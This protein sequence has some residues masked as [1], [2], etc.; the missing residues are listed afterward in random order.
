[1]TLKERKLGRE[2]RRLHK[3]NEV[4]TEENTFY[5]ERYEVLTEENTFY[6]ERY[7]TLTAEN[8]HLWM[9][10]QTLKYGTADLKGKKSEKKV[11]IKPNT[12]GKKKKRGK[13][14]G[15][16]G[17]SR[18]IPDHVD[19]VVDIIL[20]F[21]P[22]CGNP[23][24]KPFEVTKRYIE[25]IIPSTPHVTQVNTGR[26]YCTCCKK[27]VSAQSHD[28]LP[29]C[30]LGLNVTF[31]AAYMKYELHLPLAKI[32]K[33]LE[34]CFGLKTTATTIYRHIKLLS[35][36]Y[37]GEY[38]RIKGYIR[39][40]E[41]LNVDE[42]GW[43]IKGVNNWLWAFTKEDAAFF[44]IDRRRS[45]DVPLEVLG[46]DFKGVITTDFYSAYNRLLCRQQKC[47][48]HLVR[49]VK[50]FAHHNEETKK[51]YKA[52][53]QLMKEMALFKETN[54]SQKKIAKAKKRYQRRL[55]RIMN[56]SYTDPDCI[57]IAKRLKKHKD[58]MLTFLDVP[59]VE[60]HNNA[61]E[62]IIRAFVVMRKISAGNDSRQGA[63][64][65][66]IMM[67]VIVT[68]TL[69]GESFLKEGAHFIRQQIGRGI[70]IKKR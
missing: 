50:K 69:R 1:M 11:T 36:H 8:I 10:N 66:E 47:W 40:S 41:A 22:D 18:R 55:N 49:A 37:K 67:T 46:E 33:N 15:S 21:C 65:H 12:S 7:E 28:A 57:R 58:R 54:P 17:T 9:E 30:R 35:E 43:R 38:D 13:K 70:L 3:E 63:D 2:N 31:L 27:P 39:E 5:K 53:K 59:S 26:Y 4:L 42:T 20:P 25:D 23:L 68:H 62:R 48:V 61:A 60:Y 16:K 29:K 44:K 32:R 6:K 19:E 51:F 34:L 14:K 45:G 52:L 56:K 64:T 24:G